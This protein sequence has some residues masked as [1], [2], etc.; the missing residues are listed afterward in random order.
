LDGIFGKKLSFPTPDAQ[1]MLDN[2]GD[3]INYLT[4]I[5]TDN[6]QRYNDLISSVDSSY[7]NI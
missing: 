6:C 1:F 2:I 5:N 7:G 3:P 4:H